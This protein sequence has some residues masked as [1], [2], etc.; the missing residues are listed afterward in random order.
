MSR[1]RGRTGGE[2]RGPNSALTEFLRGQGI[3][4]NEIRARHLERQEQRLAMEAL[5]ARGEEQGVEAENREEDL[6]NEVRAR[7]EA[8][9]RRNRKRKRGESDSDDEDDEDFVDTEG[10]GAGGAGGPGRLRSRR[11]RQTDR[12]EEELALDG[13][14]NC[15]QCKCRFTVTVYTT[16]TADG[17]VLCRKCSASSKEKKS[18]DAAQLAVRRQRKKLAEALLDGKDLLTIPSL[19]DQC[20]AT[21]VKYIDD[22]EALGDIG[23]INLQKISRIMTRNRRLTPVILKLFL[24]PL[25]RD[26]ELWDCSSLTH[27]S[28]QSIASFC[29]HLEKLVLGMCGQLKNENLLYYATNLPNLKSIYLDGPFLINKE[30][31]ITF[32]EAVGPRLEEFHVRSTH[33]IDE[34]VIANLVINCPNLTHL[35]FH[36]LS[37]I[38][39]N[40][41]IHLIADLAHLEHLELSY[42]GDDYSQAGTGPP[43]VR[44]VTVEEEVGRDMDETP[45][46]QVQPVAEDPVD[47]VAVG[48][49]DAEDLTV[50]TDDAIVA[51][52]NKVGS[53]LK[54]LILDGCSALTDRTITAGIRPCCGELTTLS[55]TLLDQ[56]TDEAVADLFTDWTINP[57]LVKVSFRRCIGL[58]DSAIE[59]LVD[60]SRDTLVDLDLN[61]LQF[62]TSRG[63]SALKGTP[64]LTTID[65]GFVRST[66][67]RIV[68][69][70]DRSCPHLAR[71][72]V[73]GAPKVTAA[74]RITPGRKLIG[75]QSDTI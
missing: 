21:V 28:L 12:N 14:D 17:K 23:A 72:E 41:A 26:I 18:A 62:V 44:P 13:V 69:A 38:K 42:L 43:P 10:G 25:S 57:G 2:V 58:G 47:V 22:V 36:R 49:P 1:R 8:E 46:V 45:E 32:F 75:R 11:R 67:D 53:Q 51:I 65:L 27:D 63:L 6:E 48:D 40:T 68:E 24:D 29:P 73:Y 5:G 52:L 74:C 70:L 33:R 61:S 9:K 66:D 31:W 4:A 39:G 56:I 19:Q 64:N 50:V 71:V 37:N 59:A 3:S 35:T 54:T 55:L 16:Q 30:T 7:A 34:E 20:I 60:H 15:A